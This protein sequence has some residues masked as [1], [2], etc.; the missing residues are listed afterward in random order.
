MNCPGH[1]L[2]CTVNCAHPQRKE[3][4][5]ENK[6]K[7]KKKEAARGFFTIMDFMTVGLKLTGP[8]L[9]VFAL[10][11]SYSQTGGECRASR[12]Y[13]SLMTGVSLRSVERALASLTARGLLSNEGRSGEWASSNSY[14]VNLPT[15]WRELKKIGWQDADEEE[16]TKYRRLPAKAKSFIYDYYRKRSPQ[17]SG[18]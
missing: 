13:I 3:T 12:K 14:T 16:V 8:E 5:M 1:N 4:A 2:S 17:D 18:S 10:V 11:Y 15:V 6:R 9:L 7:E